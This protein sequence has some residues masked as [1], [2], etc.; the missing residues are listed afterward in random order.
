MGGVT[1]KQKLNNLKF[2]LVFTLIASIPF[3][4]LNIVLIFIEHFNDV[5]RPLCI[6]LCI[7]VGFAVVSKDDI[8]GLFK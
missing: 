2:L 3:I 8:V 5:T 1:L 6:P 4:L 7:A